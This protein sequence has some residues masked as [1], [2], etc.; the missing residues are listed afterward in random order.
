MRLSH[1]EGG[2][3][4]IHSGLAIE[5]GVILTLSSG[6][7]WAQD[8]PNGLYLTS[9][10]SLS[11]GYDDNFNTASR[12]LDDTVVLLDS[13]TFAWMKSTHQ[14]LFLLNYRPEFEIFSRHS[15]LNAWNNVADL[16]ITHQINGRVSVEAGDSFLSTMDPSR[17]L[18]NSLL[19]LPRGRF[20][21]NSFYTSLGYRLNARTKLTFRFD[22]AFTTAS[23]PGPLAGRLDQVSNAGTVTLERTLSRNQK[24][25]GSYSFLHGNPLNEAVSG[26]PTNVNQ[27]GIAYSYENPSLVVQLGG[28]VVAGSQSAFTGVA[29]VQKRLGR[30]WL[31]AGYQRYISFFENFAP[32]G[33]PAAPAGP[34]AQGVNPSSVYQVG[35]L[36]AWGQLTKRIGLEA[37]VQRALNGGNAQENSVK[38]VI[39]HLRLDYKIT[40]RLTW[41]TRLEFYG[42]NVNEFSPLSVSR[43]RYFAGLEFTLSRPPETGSRARGNTPQVSAETH[44]SEEI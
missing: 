43:S 1:P 44:P 42:Q 2:R 28:G 34:F 13:P 3:A 24:L 41:F 4:R 5:L 30:V 16:H 7:A 26:S 25:S 33:L 14:T 21:Q 17:E 9:P 10:L 35:S 27:A 18:Q 39:A 19:L 22:D 11:A 20:N 31:A 38:S 12:Q 32:V 15:E 23:L 36:R 29:A 40:D 6:L 8:H 37:V